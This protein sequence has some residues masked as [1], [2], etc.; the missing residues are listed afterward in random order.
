MSQ[1]PL[2]ILK[3]LS[4]LK[5]PESYAHAWRQR[6]REWAEIPTYEEGDTI[7][8]ASPVK[9]TDGS[10]CQLVTATHYMRSG[11]RRRC[12]R[13]A[14]TGGLTRLSKGTLAGSTLVSSGKAAGSAVL[15]EF[16]AGQGG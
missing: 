14:E 1:A 2:N 9:L 8:L 7:R 13:I 16:F 11:K 15:A 3:H 6:C 10:E 4:N 5:D 12:Y